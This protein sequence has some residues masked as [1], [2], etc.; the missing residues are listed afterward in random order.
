MFQQHLEEHVERL[1]ASNGI[2]HEWA[3]DELEPL[4]TLRFPPIGREPRGFLRQ[5]GGIR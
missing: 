5:R 1:M 4:K 2:A 3:V